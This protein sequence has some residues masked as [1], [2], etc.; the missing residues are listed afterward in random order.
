MNTFMRAIWQQPLPEFSK[1][2]LE[3]GTNRSFEKT[4]MPAK[5]AMLLMAVTFFREYSHRARFLYPLDDAQESGGLYAQ[6][7]ELVFREF[8]DSCSMKA[9]FVSFSDTANQ[10]AGDPLI[11]ALTYPQFSELLCDF[12]KTKMKNSRVLLEKNPKREK[13]M[14][15]LKGP[16]GEKVVDTIA[17][18]HSIDSKR[19]LRSRIVAEN[20]MFRELDDAGE[21]VSQE[22]LSSDKT[23]IFEEIAHLERRTAAARD[24]LGTLRIK[25]ERSYKTLATKKRSGVWEFLSDAI[26]FFTKKSRDSSK[27]ADDLVSRA[28]SRAGPSSEIHGPVK[29]VAAGKKFVAITALFQQRRHVKS[30]DQLV[31][32]QKTALSICEALLIV[33]VDDKDGE[34]GVLYTPL[35]TN[36]QFLYVK[37]ASGIMT[38][39]ILE[40][41]MSV[42]SVLYDVNNQTV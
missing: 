20:V 13:I 39:T 41:M 34:K 3:K 1:I 2:L 29:P 5:Q 30:M 9:A 18:L 6:F 42:Q 36:A 22:S 11:G 7:M 24:G 15:W 38:S 26:L 40:R 10:L 27:L 33:E 19:G 31:E 32:S 21:M 12:S 4:V 8:K 25:H 23:A 35:L 37:A 28:G 14:E 17:P 16:L